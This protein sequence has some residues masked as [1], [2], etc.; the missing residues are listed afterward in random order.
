MM[1]K[2]VR[3]QADPDLPSE[4]ILDAACTEESHFKPFLFRERFDSQESCLGLKI[5]D[6]DQPE[7]R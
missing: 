6:E 7:S 3:R 5:I 4:A 1:V 2:P